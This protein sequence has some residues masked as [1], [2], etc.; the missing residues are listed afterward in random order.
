MWLALF[1]MMNPATGTDAR[2][3]PW[4]LPTRGGWTRETAVVFMLG[5]TG[6]GL[7]ACALLRAGW[8]RA[9]GALLAG[10]LFVVSFGAWQEFLYVASYAPSVLAAVLAGALYGAL[11]ADQRAGRAVAAAC[12]LA[13]AVILNYPLYVEPAPG[14]SITYTS[15]LLEHVRFLADVPAAD[16][17]SFAARPP[18]VL[19]FLYAALALV[20]LVRA[21]GGPRSLGWVGLVIF[22]LA[23]AYPLG[24]GLEQGFRNVE[25]FR[26]AEPAHAGLEPWQAGFHI[27]GRALIVYVIP[28][29]L[30][31]FGA[32]ADLIRRPVRE[33]DAP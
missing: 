27:A 33:A 29:A 21:L 26:K 9:A 28:A 15:P 12:A 11:G 23:I 8:G 24:H 5:A 22:L 30:G 19:L 18:S 13:L 6:L 10:T 4:D 16:R 20:G 32:T 7:L 14:E 1:G 31:F 25:G 3:W 2:V 17:W